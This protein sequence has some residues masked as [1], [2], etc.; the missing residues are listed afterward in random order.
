MKANDIHLVVSN[1]HSA[2][3]L[4]CVR[5]R[6]ETIAPAEVAHRSN[7][8]CLLSDIAIRLRR[9]LRWDPDKEVFLNDDE[10]NRMLSRPWREPWHL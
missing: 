5:T 8:V 3:F 10:A 1:N 6:R 4:E 2:N 9:K 7:S